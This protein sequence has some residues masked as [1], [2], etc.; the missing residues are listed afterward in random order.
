[1]GQWG[2]LTLV[3]GLDQEEV[4]GPGKG[5]P[6]PQKW[7]SDRAAAVTVTRTDCGLVARRCRS[8]G[9][10]F[11]LPLEGWRK[12]GAHEGL[13]REDSFLSVE[14]AAGHLPPRG[15]YLERWCPQVCPFLREHARKV[16]A[17]VQESD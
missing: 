7:Q 12:K 13:E 6:R 3:T 11:P 9:T 8:L 1:M 2:V 16:Q 15:P 5:G 17:E 14:G 10:L 4:P